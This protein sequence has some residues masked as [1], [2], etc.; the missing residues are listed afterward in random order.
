MIT[1]NLNGKYYNKYNDVVRNFKMDI[2]KIPST[3]SQSL[4]KNIE[5]NG[6]ANSFSYLCL[7]LH[8][9]AVL[10]NGNP[11]Y[12][13]P[14]FIRACKTPYT[15]IWA[16]IERDPLKLMLTTNKPRSTSV[17]S[18]EITNSSEDNI[19]TEEEIVKLEV[20]S[21]AVDPKVVIIKEYPNEEM[22]EILKSR[23]SNAKRIVKSFTP[24]IKLQ[25][26]HE[27][28]LVEMGNNRKNKDVVSYVLEL[29]PLIYIGYELISQL[30]DLIEKMQNNIDPIIIDEI[31]TFHSKLQQHVDAMQIFNCFSKIV[32]NEEYLLTLK[33]EFIKIKNDFQLF[34]IQENIDVF[35]EIIHSL[36][37]VV[38]K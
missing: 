35:S 23:A 5:F 31:Q 20:L 4:F 10:F 26:F 24:K 12:D 19:N 37:K 15:T 36:N 7:L 29:S 32:D 28:Q 30:D 18:Q 2:L 9:P 3:L 34:L 16:N 11:N 13:I 33:Y 25:R 17:I 1:I 38:I 21:V 22:K 14:N 8:D 6:S 27:K